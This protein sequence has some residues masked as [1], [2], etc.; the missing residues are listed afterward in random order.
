MVYRN[1]QK[2]LP[3]ARPSVATRLVLLIAVAMSAAAY[4]EA[5]Y[6]TDQFEITMRT[7]PST[8][9][10]IV[11]ML[12]TG[13]TLELISSDSESGYSEV[14]TT[15]GTQGFVLTRYLVRNPVAR[16]QLAT[17]QERVAALRESSGE[18]G[19]T[20]DDLREQNI[21][22]GQQVAQ[23]EADKAQLEAELADIRET[24]S[25]VL[26]IN[27]QNRTLMDGL[28]RTQARILELEQANESLVAR[29]DQNWFLIGAAVL[30][31]GIFLGIVLPRI[32]R[33]RRKSWSNSF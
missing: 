2:T 9:N 24:A 33:K 25:D 30:L 8:D 18:Q 3:T 12:D 23:L 5:R 13:A 6:V 20:L 22:Y 28:S 14:R 15:G 32:P 21:E 11:R 16:A 31:G 4:G 7:G 19:R 10:A 26:A 17:L 1:A 29:H 27:D